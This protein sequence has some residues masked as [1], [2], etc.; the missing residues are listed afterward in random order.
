VQ[1]GDY[2]LGFDWLVGH[3]DAAAQSW[4]WAAWSWV[5][6]SGAAMLLWG[7]GFVAALRSSRAVEKSP[8]HVALFVVLVLSFWFAPDVLL[9][10]ISGRPEIFFALWALS[11]LCVRGRARLLAWMAVGMVM[12]TWYWFFWIYVPA[13]L[14]LWPERGVAL[15]AFRDRAFVG[16]SILTVG[17]AFWAIVS[18][19]H[20]GEWFLH[21]HQALNAREL[22]VGENAGLAAG[23]IV[24]PG[25]TVLIAGLTLAAQNG[26]GLS[27]R[28]RYTVLVLAALCAWFALP[29][30][31]RYMDS[32]ASL[33]V[34]GLWIVGARLLDRYPPNPALRP[35]WA[36][37][38]IVVLLW[39]G[40]TLGAG[41]R[42]L[43]D[44]TLP[45]AQP[46][47]RVLTFFSADTYDTLYLNPQVRVAPAFE[48]G[49]S[50]PDVQRASA[51][52][53]RGQ[54]SCAWLENNRVRWVIAP[55]Q[56]TFE[57]KDWT[58]CLS[59]VKVVHG[60]TVWRV[61]PHARS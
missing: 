1:Q 9:R 38:C 39:G 51:N 60:K 52:L 15:K 46:G 36:A 30:M 59:L 53:A 3:I 23:L 45:G 28:E 55:A 54:V 37:L 11:A 33:G 16:A 22:Q 21:L 10:M 24:A 2:Y 12:T 26:V 44:L 27:S 13:T 7:V 42:H 40:I 14:L 49:F 43:A 58:P 17:L 35:L 41:S 34:A 50:R 31:V 5:P 32:I 25:L 8:E 20:Y 48:L 57:A 6:V 29:N 56:G 4:G 47:D 18:G 61:F 19:G